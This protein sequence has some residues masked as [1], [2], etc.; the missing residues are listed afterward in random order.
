MMY[1]LKYETKASHKRLSNRYFFLKLEA[2]PLKFVQNFNTRY[3][4]FFFFEFAGKARDVAIW[5][6]KTQTYR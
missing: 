5:Y 2:A 6:S 4:V 1:I 3:W